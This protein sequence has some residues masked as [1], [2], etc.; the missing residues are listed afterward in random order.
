MNP[1]P[2]LFFVGPMVGLRALHPVVCS[3]AGLQAL[4]EVTVVAAIPRLSTRDAVRVTTLRSAR[5]WGFSLLSVLVLASAT[6]LL[7]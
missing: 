3:Y 5:N 4:S 2:N 6:V 7:G 1:A